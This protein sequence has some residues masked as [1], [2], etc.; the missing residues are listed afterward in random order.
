MAELGSREQQAN[1][2]GRPRRSLVQSGQS[3]RKPNEFC[4]LESRHR[5]GLCYVEEQLEQL[6]GA[7]SS[8]GEAE[9]K[10]HAA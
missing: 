8:Y 1:A 7:S 10:R 4:P 2:G 5:I 9:E 3:M 6:A